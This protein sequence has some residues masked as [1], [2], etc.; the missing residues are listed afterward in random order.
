[1]QARGP[2]F[3][4]EP[5]ECTSEWAVSDPALARLS[6]DR[7]ILHIAEEA[8]PGAELIIS[9]KAGGR[10]VRRS[11]RIVG[12]DEAVLTGLRSQR[13]V[14]LCNVASPVR[15]L[16]FTENGFFTVTFMPFETYKDY[17]GR[18]RFD[19]ETGKLSLTVEDGNHT[20]EGL[21]LEGKARFDPA[22]NLVLEDIFLGQPLST[23]S[24]SGGP[25]RYTF[26]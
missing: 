22:G 6:E 8:A 3:P 17:W 24:S 5:M 1:M 15:E 21:D 23:R 2:A 4:A 26:G 10:L 19:P 16:Q 25:C 18:Y 20:P 7:K 14:E 9:Y 11:V 13:A 12:K